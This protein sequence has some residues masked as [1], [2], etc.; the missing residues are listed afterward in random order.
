MGGQ[1]ARLLRALGELCQL[2]STYHHAQLL[3]EYIQLFP[4]FMLC[5]QGFLLYLL[6]M[7]AA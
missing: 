3:E 4:L 7:E 5:T 1:K 2:F 6:L